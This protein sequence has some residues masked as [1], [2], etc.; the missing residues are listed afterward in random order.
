MLP[1]VS[2]IICKQIT[3]S[4]YVGNIGA[5]DCESITARGFT[6]VV[7]RPFLLHSLYFKCAFCPVQF[8][9]L[10]S[11]QS[12][13]NFEV[14]LPPAVEGLHIDVEDHD[15]ANLLDELPDALEFIDEALEDGGKVLVHCHAGVSRSTAVILAY[16]CSSMGLSLDEALEVLKLDHPC[17][18][19]NDGFMR[20]LALFVKMGY[21]TE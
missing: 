7:V 2:A 10:C 1:T 20:Q 4:V 13:V 6:H 16:M 8:Q 11:T 19:P 17:A 3:V 15:D 12:V 5:A 9:R 18:M 14:P 21:A